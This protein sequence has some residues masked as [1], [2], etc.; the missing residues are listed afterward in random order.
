MAQLARLLAVPL[1][2][3]QEGVCFMS[4]P[5]AFQRA[6]CCPAASMPTA[7]N[8]V[9][10][11]QDTLALT[12]PALLAWLERRLR[13]GGPSS[14]RLTATN[15]FNDAQD[16]LALTRPALLAWLERRL[17]PGA[18]GGEA[19]QLDFAG[20]LRAQHAAGAVSFE[21]KGPPQGALG[22]QAGG[23]ELGNIVSLPVQWE[24][25]EREAASQVEA[26]LR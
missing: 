13:P 8:E 18:P 22:A 20:W 25:G 2:S 24:R 4:M 21:F 1:L 14:T 12:R 23:G 19:A 10:E 17:R 15:K 5:S 7:T 26:A 6:W 16:T 3:T 11:V 9:T